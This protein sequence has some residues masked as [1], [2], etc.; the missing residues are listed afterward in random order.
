MRVPEKW[1]PAQAYHLKVARP[2]MSYSRD[3][4]S[5]RLEAHHAMRL[6]NMLEKWLTSAKKVPIEAAKTATPLSWKILSLTRTLNGSINLPL[7]NTCFSSGLISL[8]AM[9][10]NLTSEGTWFLLCSHPAQN[11]EDIS[12]TP[13]S[14]RQWSSKQSTV[15]VRQS[16]QFM[17]EIPV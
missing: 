4:T 5:L 16:A 1:I 3:D 9:A 17:S 2:N 6:L 10:L 15:R 7:Y 13:P 8:A 11:N 14:E 12:E